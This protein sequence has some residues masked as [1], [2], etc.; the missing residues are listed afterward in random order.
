MEI[1][2]KAVYVPPYPL[3]ICKRKKPPHTQLIENPPIKK[4]LA[5]WIFSEEE[6]KKDV[7]MFEDSLSLLE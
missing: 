3:K 1:N 2:T 4:E 5:F 6:K 7:N